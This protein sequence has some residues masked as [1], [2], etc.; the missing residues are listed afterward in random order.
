MP[1]DRAKELDGRLE[2]Q[3]LEQRGSDQKQRLAQNT[4]GD[5]RWTVLLAN[6]SRQSQGNVRNVQVVFGQ[7]A[8][9]LDD[10]N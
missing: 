8:G 4:R 2:C 3:S 7:E 10:D 6:E 1:H 9:Q 5:Q